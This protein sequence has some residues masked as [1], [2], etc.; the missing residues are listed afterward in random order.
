MVVDGCYPAT[1][2]AELQARHLSRCLRQAGHRVEIIAPRLETWQDQPIEVD[3]CTVRYLKY[4]RSIK[5]VG[6]AWLM[7]RFAV[8]L[9]F[10]RRRYDAIHIHIA[11]NLACV[12]G[13]LRPLLGARIIVKVSGA[14][15]FQGGILDPEL[16]HKPLHRWLNAGIRRVDALQCIS[17]YTEQMLRGTGYPAARLISLPNAVDCERFQPRR[18]DG[19]DGLRV[20]FVGRHVPVKGIDTLIRAWARLD[21]SRPMRLVLAGAGPE[22]A[23]LKALCAELGVADSVEFPGEVHD[24]PALLSGA[25]VYV[26]ASHREGLPNAVLEA[27]ASGLPIVATRISGHED[28]VAHGHNGLLVPVNDADA[29]AAALDTLLRDPAKRQRMGLA[30]RE[31]MQQRYCTQRVLS[32]LV[33]LYRGLDP[34]SDATP[35]MTEAHTAGPPR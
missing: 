18:R 11:R 4:P 9:L 22:S 24:V 2:G 3:G 29:M 14:Y 27:M 19:S 21:R 6:P 20:V 13:W 12:A 23:A 5:G 15:E 1:G 17:R 32:R 26:Q 28:V 8:F 10:R 30:S 31:V 34:A 35:T 7:F 16:K 25:D 33:A